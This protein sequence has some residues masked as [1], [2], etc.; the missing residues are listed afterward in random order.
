[1]CLHSGRAPFRNWLVDL[2]RTQHGEVPSAFAIS[3]VLGALEARAAI[4]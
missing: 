1:M 3:Q 4:R 2:Y